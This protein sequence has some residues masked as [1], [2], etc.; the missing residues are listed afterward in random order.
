MVE[1]LLFCV[2]LLQ[3]F[4]QN[5]TQHSSIERI[6]FKK[7]VKFSYC[8]RSGMGKLRLGGLM[9]PASLFCAARGKKRRECKE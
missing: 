9:R 8:S 5:S 4:V 2:M 6:D 3:G 1:Q 7:S